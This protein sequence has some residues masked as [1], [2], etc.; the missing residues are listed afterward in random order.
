MNICDLL[1]CYVRSKESFI[2]HLY[3]ALGVSTVAWVCVSVVLAVASYTYATTT[4][5]LVPPRR[6]ITPDNY[7]FFPPSFQNLKFTLENYIYKTRKPHI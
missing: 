4:P 3:V 2:N 7:T 1:V 6:H 5:M